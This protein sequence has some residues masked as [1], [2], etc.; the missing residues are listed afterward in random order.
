M[1]LRFRIVF[2]CCCAALAVVLCLAYAGRVREE[3]QRLRTQMLERYGGEVV[4]LV[5]STAQLEPGDVASQSNVTMRE[6]ISDL[7]PEGALTSLD[8]VLG[9]EVGVATPKG[10]PLTDLAFRSSTELADVPAGHVAL[11]LPLTDKLGVPRGVGQGVTLVAYA[12][13]TEGTKSISGEMTVLAAPSQTVL[14]TGG[15]ITVALLPGDV[16][17]VL[18]ASASGDLRLVMPGDAEAPQDT[19]SQAPV[20]LSEADEAAVPDGDAAK[21]EGSADEDAADEAAADSAG[22][23]G[24]ATSSSEAA[25]AEDA[26][27]QKGGTP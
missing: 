6:W 8:D 18:S 24:E 1:S 14:G 2:S 3:E 9:R 23:S 19:G 15:Q 25:P 11:S 17:A 5:V 16:P 21:S 27:S 22:A 13:T 10:A 26:P 12:V 20:D 4:S 7:A